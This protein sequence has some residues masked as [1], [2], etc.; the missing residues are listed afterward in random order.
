ML[1]IMTAALHGCGG[2]EP[3][4]GEPSV[5]GL[6]TRVT[7]GSDGLGVILVEETSPQGLDYD[8]GSLT[9]AADTIVA[10]Q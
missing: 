3:P 1:V 5:R 8:K 6:I 4:S 10:L 7:P 9:I 2:L